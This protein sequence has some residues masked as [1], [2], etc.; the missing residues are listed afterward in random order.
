M[1][2]ILAILLLQLP[3]VSI[4]QYNHIPNPGFELH[5]NCPNSYGQVSLMCS[6]WNNYHGS[7]DYF[8]KCANSNFVGVPINNRGYQQSYDSAY[9]GI[10]LHSSTN[11]EY[12]I[13]PIKPLSV[14]VQYKVALSIS[15]SNNSNA[16]TD[17]IGVFF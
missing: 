10:V 6:F 5:S 9:A 7:A 3:I 1:K 11:F 15:L 12:V 16:A 17:N 8:H 2:Y 4:G 14:G 13:T